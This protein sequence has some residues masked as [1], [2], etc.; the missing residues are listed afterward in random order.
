MKR[1]YDSGSDKPAYLQ[2][3]DGLREAIISGVYTY[4]EK[5]PSKRT[6]AQEQ[7]LSVVTAEHALSLLA[8]EGYI[9]SSERS[10]YF[11]EF[12]R[13]DGFAAAP[14]AAHGLPVH[15]HDPILSAQLPFPVSVLTKTM[16]RVL[17]AQQ[18]EIL[19][20]SP[21]QGRMELRE[22]I[23]TYLRRSRGIEA[24]PEQIVIGCGSEHLYALVVQLLG[25]DR[26]YGIESPSYKKIQQV[27]ALHGV[28]YRMLPLGRDGIE[29][30]A[31]ARTDADVLH[32]TPYRSFPSGVTASASK[33][34]AYLQWAQTGDRYLIEDD[35]ESEFSLSR[36]PEETLFAH[37]EKENVLYLNTFSK[38]ISPSL[39][40]GYLV[41]PQPL[42]QPYREKVG[43]SACPV[44]TFVQLVLSELLMNGDFERQINR[45]RRQKRREA[46]QT[47]GAR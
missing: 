32:I 2:L 37:G 25:R 1:F 14:S 26:I 40:V 38:T 34:H 15:V 29:S 27:Y 35:Y 8:D 7:G 33:R 41:L 23:S 30:A 36:K 44:S 43:F 39:R 16:R 13:G 21:E 18:E 20:P 28:T 47:S 42:V 9:R 31:L 4:G 3:Y 10:G 6:L 12:R 24:S 45:V 19:S 46:S 17:A 5:L 11:V 22:A